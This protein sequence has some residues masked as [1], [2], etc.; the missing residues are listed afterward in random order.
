MPAFISASSQ[1]S[2]LSLVMIG[3]MVSDR[4]FC[5]AMWEITAQRTGVSVVSVGA[6]F[7]ANRADIERETNDFVTEW[8]VNPFALIVCDQSQGRTLVFLVR[9]RTV[10]EV[11]FEGGWWLLL[12][13]KGSLTLKS[14]PIGGKGTVTLR[15]TTPTLRTCTTPVIHSLHW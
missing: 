5:R 11:A 10:A 8:F 2:A 4:T 12:G 7:T 15:T 3:K 9:V 6:S 14:A 1:A 13:M